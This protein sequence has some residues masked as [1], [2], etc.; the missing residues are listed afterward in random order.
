[1]THREDPRVRT[2]DAVMR[3]IWR[4]NTA[5]CLGIPCA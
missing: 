3:G 2:R 4:G 5:T 1:M